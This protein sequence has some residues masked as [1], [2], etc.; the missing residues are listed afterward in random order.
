MATTTVEQIKIDIQVTS[1]S[2]EQRIKRLEE[3]LAR[4][5]SEASSAADEA[6]GSMEEVGASASSSSSKVSILTRM[7]H[8]L[9]SAVKSA[10]KH[11][12]KSMFST[13]IAP[14]R[15]IVGMVNSVKSSIGSIISSFKRIA[16][17]RLFR[18]AIRLL[19]QGFKEGKEN[20]Y[21]FSE[22]AGTQFK[23]SMDSMATSALYMKNSLA[24]IAEPILNYLAPAIDLLADRFAALAATV[25][26]FFAA[27]TGQDQYTI[28]LKFPKEYGEEAEETAKAMQKWLGPFDEIN[29]L[30]DPA[31]SGKSTDLD[32]TKMFETMV[33]EGT[34]PIG[35]FVRMLKEGIAEGDLSEVGRLLG[36]KL[37]DALDNIDWEKTKAK[38]RKIASSI[39]TF[40]TSFFTTPGFAESIGKSIAEAFNTGIEFFYTLAQKLDFEALGESLGRGIQNF[41]ETFDFKK[42][43]GTIVDWGVGFVTFLGTAIAEVDW[44]GFGKKIGEG[45]R[46]VDWYKA[47]KAVFDLGSTILKSLFDVVVGV[48]TGGTIGDVF[49]GFG[50]AVGDALA[51]KKL[52]KKAF[53]AVTGLGTALVQGLFSAIGGLISG[54]TGQD[55]NLRLDDESAKNIFVALF[56]GIT[57]VKFLSWILGAGGAGAAVTTAGAGLSLSIPHVALALG[58]VTIASAVVGKLVTSSHWN[59]EKSPIALDWDDPTAYDQWVDSLSDYQR[60][61]LS[62]LMQGMTQL[63]IDMGRDIYGEAFSAAQQGI[64]FGTWYEGISGQQYMP[65][66]GRGE[67]TPLDTY[68]S[69]ETWLTQFEQDAGIA[70]SAVDRIKQK[71]SEAGVTAQQTGFCFADAGGEMADGMKDADAAAK[72]TNKTIDITSA[73]A[74]SMDKAFKNSAKHSVTSIDGIKKAVA[75]TKK[76]LSGKNPLGNTNFA[77]KAAKIKNS[78]KAAGDAIKGIRTQTDAT[79]KKLSGKNPLGHSE[80]D[81][82]A[83]KIKGSAK[84]VGDEIVKIGTSSENAKT[85]LASKM[86]E[87]VTATGTFKT[88]AMSHLNA[89]SQ[90]LTSGMA[91]TMTDFVDEGNHGLDTMLRNYAKFSGET[92]RLMSDVQATYQGVTFYRYGQGGG[93]APQQR[94]FTEQQMYANGGFVDSGEVFIARENNA[95]ELVGQ[96]GNRTGVAN[97]AQ[98]IAGIAAG[99][100]DANTVVVSAIYAGINQVIGAIRENR[101][102]NGTVN[103]DAVARQ[104]TRVQKRQA[105]SQ[106]V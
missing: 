25:A 4:L 52:W 5:R 42:F 51:D 71:L 89:F 101:S 96:F 70:E 59:P 64:D 30:S 19:T 106:Y 61:L 18:S 24:T 79:K 38:A 87:M 21:H 98:I 29:R 104:I 83:K 48:T 8:S 94:P 47:F 14:A 41:L 28:A 77:D 76:A 105:A 63:E 102:G 7:M 75:R 33:V 62:E 3:A 6:S 68:G 39:G 31:K 17:Y 12:L 81:T 36:E 40:I 103:W 50:K 11:G 22:Y 2:A 92:A 27:L 15:T 66:S 57:A 34:G 44:E 46:D 97:N 88:N 86:G 56:G 54:I 90:G 91:T 100:E 1:E 58:A 45:I 82:K 99:V 10:T 84:S 93:P 35:E 16:M 80:F 49:E 23:S 78:A 85:K 74:V 20:L 73:K 72:K 53:Q 69:G 65:P 95:P 43:I 60:G 32:F 13:A 67:G 55:I 37:R 9:G 26:E